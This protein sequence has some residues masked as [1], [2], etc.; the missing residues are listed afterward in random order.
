MLPLFVVGNDSESQNSEY[1]AN[2]EP[3]NSMNTFSNWHIAVWCHTL[4]CIITML[5]SCCL[6][7][8]GWACLSHQVENYYIVKTHFFLFKYTECVF[9]LYFIFLNNNEQWLACHYKPWE[10]LVPEYTWRG[11]K[12][13]IIQNK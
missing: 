8:S 10:Q 4:F 9:N 13:A 11:R 2:R 5:C 1:C 6:R 7:W 12:V 3:R